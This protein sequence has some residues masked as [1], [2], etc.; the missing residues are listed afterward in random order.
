MRALIALSVVLVL[1]GCGTKPEFTYSVDQAVAKAPASVKERCEPIDKKMVKREGQIDSVPMGD[2]YKQ[3][4][5]LIGLYGECA[6]RDAAKA[7][8]MESQGH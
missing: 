3:S 5:Y 1:A 6:A 2:L 8:W 4:D 7:E